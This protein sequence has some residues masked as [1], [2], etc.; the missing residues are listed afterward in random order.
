MRLASS[1]NRSEKSRSIG[2]PS[3]GGRLPLYLYHAP[4]WYEGQY[5]SLKINK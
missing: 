3:F 5:I 4:K 2:K 1:R